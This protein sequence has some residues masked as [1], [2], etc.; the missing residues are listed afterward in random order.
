MA[1]SANA[2]RWAVICGAIIGIF[3]AGALLGQNLADRPPADRQ[4]PDRQSAGQQPAGL[5]MDW[6]IAPTLQAIG[7]H[8][9]RL[10][11][12][13]EKIDVYAWVEKGASDT[14]LAQ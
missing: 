14:Y 2:V 5:E 13:L 10:L 12:V 4:P 1:F 9:D 8:A 11:P 7:A 6:D 3:T